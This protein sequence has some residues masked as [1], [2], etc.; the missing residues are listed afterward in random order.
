VTWLAY[1][2]CGREFWAPQA[3]ST[4]SATTTQVV[5]P[6]FAFAANFTVG[7][8]GSVSG[9]VVDSAGGVSGTGSLA[10]TE[11]GPAGIV[12]N[13]SG[14]FIYVANHGGGTSAYSVSRNTGELTPIA[15]APFS[16]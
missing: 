8:K 3:T 12:S 5:T 11:N 14:T 6:K 13:S 9:Y 4:S 7:G 15:W 16:T 10:A 2:G 1:V